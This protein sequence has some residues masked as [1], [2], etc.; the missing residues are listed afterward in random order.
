MPL[1]NAAFCSDSDVKDGKRYVYTVRAVSEDGSGYL[2]SYDPQGIAI[3][4][5]K[6]EPGEEAPAKSAASEETSTLPSSLPKENASHPVLYRV[7]IGFG[8]FAAIAAAVF[9]TGLFRKKR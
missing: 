4:Y 1:Q 7:L 3:R 5:Q 8:I 2:S 6:P 9:L